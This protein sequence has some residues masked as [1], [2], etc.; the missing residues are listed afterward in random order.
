MKNLE[1]VRRSG[2]NVT[3]FVAKFCINMIEAIKVKKIALS[4]ISFF[5]NIFKD[6]L[7]AHIYK[8]STIIK[9]RP[10]PF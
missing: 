9:C 10:V 1:K 6:L 8:T 3:C 2:Y 7:S 4:F 5:T